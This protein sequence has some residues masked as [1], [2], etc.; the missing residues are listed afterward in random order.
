M[1]DLTLLDAEPGD[2]FSLPLRRGDVEATV[3]AKR[4]ADLLV[5]F[6][7]AGGAPAL[8]IYRLTTGR[9]HF[10]NALTLGKDWRFAVWCGGVGFTPART[11]AWEA[12][13]QHGAFALSESHPGRYVPRS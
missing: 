7:T 8:A 6:L 2:T 13:I 3:I 11:V 10:A 4:E 5:E 12:A 1:T 9:K